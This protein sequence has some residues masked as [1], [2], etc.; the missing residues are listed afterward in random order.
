MN[1]TPTLEYRRHLPTTAPLIGGHTNTSSD[2][3]NGILFNFCS[4]HNKKQA[5]FERGLIQ[6]WNSR[7]FKTS[8]Q[9][10]ICIAAALTSKQ[11]GN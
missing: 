5:V 6:T 1:A 10:V 3:T 2:G 8:L 11:Y 4:H 9:I 7:D